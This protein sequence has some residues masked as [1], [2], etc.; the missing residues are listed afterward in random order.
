M[1]NNQDIELK[2]YPIWSNFLYFLAALYAG[3]ISISTLTI[4]KYT[5]NEK[6]IMFGI[7]SILLLLTGLFSIIYHIH[8]PSWTENPEVINTQEF[9]TWLNVDKAF[10]STLTAFAL[11]FLA[12][13]IYKRRSKLIFYDSNFWF[14][15]LFI[16]L[17]LTFYIIADNHGS[18]ALDCKQKNKQKLEKCFNTNIDGYD[19]FHSNWH[20]FTS[21]A[22]IFWISLLNNSYSW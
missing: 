3:I 8:T 14:A 19:I 22:A 2:K 1:D 5:L 10:A 12:L 9:N 4:K 20:I 18:N 13:R 17:S 21:I 6:S 7:F 11:F 15:I 16:I